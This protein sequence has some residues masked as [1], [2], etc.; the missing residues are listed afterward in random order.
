M[1]SSFQSINSTMIYLSCCALVLSGLVFVADNPIADKMAFFVFFIHAAL[2][3]RDRF[4]LK[5]GKFKQPWFLVGALFPPVY[6]L[7]RK[8]ITGKDV[9]QLLPIA[10]IVCFFIPPI[11]FT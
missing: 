11:L 4:K 10:W 2:V 3:E 6:V 7:W 9:S 5:A 8:E 1:K